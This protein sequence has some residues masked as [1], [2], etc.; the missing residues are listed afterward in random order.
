MRTLVLRH[1]RPWLVAG[2]ARV[3]L[4]GS[5]ARQDARLRSDVDV[6]VQ[7]NLPQGTLGRLREA[8]EE[9]RVHV[10]VDVV[11]LATATGPLRQAVEQEGIEWRL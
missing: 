9:S 10:A 8:L 7:G 6:A 11:D 2:E 5:Q 4:F 1:L 3:W